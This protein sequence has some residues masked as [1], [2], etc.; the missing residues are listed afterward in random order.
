MMQRVLMNHS[1]LGA[2]GVKASWGSSNTFG[3]PLPVPCLSLTCFIRGA[4][5]AL[6]RVGTAADLAGTGG[7]HGVDGCVAPWGRDSGNPGCT[8]QSTRL[9]ACPPP[10]QLWLPL[11]LLVLF[12]I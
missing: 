6:R 7:G 4:G 1:R 9:G 8:V 3:F 10:R 5:D 12:L 2:G 11:T